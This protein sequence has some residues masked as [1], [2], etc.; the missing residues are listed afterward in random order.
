MKYKYIQFVKRA[1]TD[2]RITSVWRCKNR[3]S[4]QELGIVRWYAPWRKYCYFPTSQAVY[5]PGCLE[6]IADFISKE[7][8]K[9]KK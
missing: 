9:R 7:M 1:T 8:E 2:K 4:G 6:D 5:S 3:K